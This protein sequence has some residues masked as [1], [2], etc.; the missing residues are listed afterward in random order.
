MSKT[1]KNILFEA[2]N[3]MCWN[4]GFDR[5]DQEDNSFLLTN[6][7]F[8]LYYISGRIL[9]DIHV[10]EYKQ[11]MEQQTAGQNTVK[12]E[13][14]KNDES[15]SNLFKSEVSSNCCDYSTFV[16]N[17]KQAIDCLGMFC[18]L[19]AQKLRNKGDKELCLLDKQILKLHLNEFSVLVDDFDVKKV[20]QFR[21]GN[22]QDEQRLHI[23]QFEYIVYMALSTLNG[24]ATTSKH[25]APNS[26]IHTSIVVTGVSSQ[27]DKHWSQ[28]QETMGYEHLSQIEETTSN[29]GKIDKSQ[30]T[31][32]NN[33]YILYNL[34]VKFL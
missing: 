14:R 29:D 3:Y 31:E 33:Y 6:V 21:Q 5:M 30:H 18:G 11:P 9:Q 16:H 28:I 32:N 2:F 4:L 10:N 34:Q 25:K 27:V 12:E 15:I 26:A 7:T 13:L 17:T 1:K 19:E 8:Q 24:K 23:A 20:F 22:D